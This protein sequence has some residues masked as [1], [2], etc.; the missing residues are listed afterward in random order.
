MIRNDICNEIRVLIYFELT[1][2][3]I[4]CQLQILRI[5]KYTHTHTHTHSRRK[6]AKNRPNIIF[7]TMAAIVRIISPRDASVLFDLWS[8]M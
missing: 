8:Q 5:V 2:L 4:M 3:V 7:A 6:E 1:L